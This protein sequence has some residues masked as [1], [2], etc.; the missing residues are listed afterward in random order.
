M[1]YRLQIGED[2]QFHLPEGLLIRWVI[3]A[4]LGMLLLF[5]S[6]TIHI[7]SDTPAFFLWFSLVLNTVILLLLGKE[8]I[9]VSIDEFKTRRFSL[10]TLIFIGVFS[11][12]LL[13]VTNVFRGVPSAIYF[14]T[15]GMILVFYIGS[16]LI[17][18]YLKNKIGAYSK[19]WEPEA[20]ALLVKNNN[21]VWERVSSE[22][23]SEGDEIKTEAEKV[24]PAD[25][26][27]RSERGYV[28]EAHL[29]GEPTA[30]LK[31]EGDGIM[32]GSI[33][34][35]EDLIIELTSSFSRSSL[36][37][38]LEQFEWEKKK[39]SSYE[40]ISSR[41]A[42]I[43]LGTVVILSAITLIYYI[44]IGETSS[45]INNF[46]SVLIIGCP[47]AFAIATPAAIWI[48]HKSLHDQGILLRTGSQAIEELSKVTHIIFDKTGTITGSA[49][50]RSVEIVGRSKLKDQ[51][52]MKLLVGIEAVD[53]HPVAE[54][55][56]EFG[57]RNQIM[58]LH[59][60]EFR[61]MQGLGIRGVWIDENK[62]TY[63]IA[64]LNRAHPEA[65]SLEKNCFGL[66]V[67]K[68]MVIKI[69][70]FHPLKKD[71]KNLLQRLSE[72]GYKVS[73]IS[74]DPEP[75]DEIVSDR[76]TYI[77]NMSPHEKAK[78]VERMKKE[79]GKVLFIG[80]GL[81][82]LLA[83]AKADSTIAMFEGS[84]KNKV[85]ADMVFYNPDIKQLKDILNQAE[86]TKKTI[87]QNFFW[88]LI[89]NIIGLPLAAIGLLSPLISIAAMILSSIFVTTNSLRLN[90]FNRVSN[91]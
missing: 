26:I 35:D 21:G 38:Y 56:R 12:Y 36:S 33:A 44:W 81:N 47:C 3:A 29:T 32:A 76:W 22:N 54:A 89:Y 27:L 18:I 28:R 25:G 59:I 34:L 68:E 86:Q 64:L 37:S 78:Y 74:G 1:A 73:V 30:I 61:K 43:L 52:L 69:E 49:N 55:V 83:M 14:E 2:G 51:T 77:G 20:P 4:V 23:L 63:E 70:I 85:E 88:A 19:K 82:D 24:I 91:D 10:G 53:E 6:L 41:A 48:T 50:V 72:E 65:E 11:S 46:L 9:L 75:Q 71:A 13:S 67:N 45:A 7:D 39:L 79:N 60:S 5:V 42:S 87:Y 8:V 80:D 84:D 31:K 90:R 17:D 16:L 15:S 62:Q 40:T 57:R 58:P 66:F